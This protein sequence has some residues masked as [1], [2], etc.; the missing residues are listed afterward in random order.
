[1]HFDGQPLPMLTPARLDEVE[2]GAH[3]VVVGLYGHKDVERRLTLAAGEHR[4]LE[5]T[6]TPLQAAKER[7]GKPETQ[8]RA[9][10]STGYLTAKSIPWADV[11]L[12]GRKL[13]T[14]PLA[15]IELPAGVHVLTFKNAAQGLV[16]RRKVTIR[17]GATTKLALELGP[18]SR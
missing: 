16:A 12:G 10:P 4:T 6:L 15:E 11:Y 5:V 7:P 8:A 9:R 3:V 13:G 2:A 17:P 14:T 1:V 18:G